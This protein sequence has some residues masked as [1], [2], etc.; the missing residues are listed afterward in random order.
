MSAWIPYVLTLI[1]GIVLGIGVCALVV[2]VS[3]LRRNEQALRCA[4]RVIQLMRMPMVDSSYLGFEM[5]KEMREAARI[6][7]VR[8]VNDFL[9]IMSEYYPVEK[10]LFTRKDLKPN[11]APESPL[12]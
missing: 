12:S 3:L 5:S 6:Y 7:Y 11:L 10:K 2:Y 9:S 1:S 4:S 8:G